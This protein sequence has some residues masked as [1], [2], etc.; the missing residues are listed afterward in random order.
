M[1]INLMCVLG[2]FLPA[3]V[4][5]LKL[6]TRPDRECLLPSDC[7][8]NLQI[9]RK[10]RTQWLV[11]VPIKPFYMRTMNCQGLCCS[12]K[13]Q[14]SPLV[15]IPLLDRPWPHSSLPSLFKLGVEQTGLFSRE[16]HT[17]ADYALPP[18]VFIHH[19]PPYPLFLIICP[20]PKPMVPPRLSVPVH[21]CNNILTAIVVC[22][23]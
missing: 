1:E 10:L 11:S 14:L 6:C 13:C 8:L 16:G 18:L 17:A 23:S 7:V 12:L 20:H 19:L 2:V 3:S 9:M 21:T 4:F 15:M 22:T 5:R